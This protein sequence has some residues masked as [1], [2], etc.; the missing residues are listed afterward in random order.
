MS[1]EKP[2]YRLHKPTTTPAGGIAERGEIIEHEGVPNYFFEPVN[3][4]AFQRVVAARFDPLAWDGPEA[5]Q[6]AAALR[7]PT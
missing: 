6:I 7:E 3:V 5:K 4:P 1:N 2:R